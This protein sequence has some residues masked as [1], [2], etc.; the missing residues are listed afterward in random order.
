MHAVNATCCAEEPRTLA[1][2]QKKYSDLKSAVKR[3]LSRIKKDRNKTGCGAPTSEELSTFESLVAQ[4]VCE[5]EV[6]GIP[7]GVDIG[8]SSHDS[9]ALHMVR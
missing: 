9:R 1:E 3:K 4:S 7:S 5:E 8:M 6:A 2:V